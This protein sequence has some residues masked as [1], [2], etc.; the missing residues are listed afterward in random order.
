M[1]D[2]F[3]RVISFLDCLQ[4]IS[5]SLIGLAETMVL[6][7]IFYLQCKFPS[8]IDFE[9]REVQGRSYFPYSFLKSFGKFGGS[10]P[11]N[12]ICWT[13]NPRRKLDF[14]EEQFKKPTKYTI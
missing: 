4:F 8:L 9:F 3:Y 7:N 13:F 10:C 12:G 2:S 6:S 14:T 11:E 5:E 1:V